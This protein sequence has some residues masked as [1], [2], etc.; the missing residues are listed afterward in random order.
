MYLEF[1]SHDLSALRTSSMEDIK[2]TSGNIM[3]KTTL[4]NMKQG[5][6]KT[7]RLQIRHLH[8]LP[9]RIHHVYNIPLQLVTCVPTGPY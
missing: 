7:K 4:R 3:Y 5:K 2:Y 6:N 1:V 8:Q 9:H